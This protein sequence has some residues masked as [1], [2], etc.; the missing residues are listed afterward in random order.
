MSKKN[1][2]PAIPPDKRVVVIA[3]LHSGHLVGLTP[4]QYQHE[5]LDETETKHNKYIAVEKACWDYFETE[6]AKL[7]PVHIL[8]VNGDCTDGRGEKSGGVELLTTSRIKQAEMATKAILSCE[9]EY[10]VGTYG[11]DYHV[12]SDGEDI[13]DIVYKD[14][15]DSLGAAAVKWGAHEWF[16]VHGVTFDAKHHVSFSGVPHTQYTAV[17]RDALW[18]GV[19]S[20]RREA[21]AAQVI[22]RSHVHAFAYCG[23]KEYLAMTTPALQGMGS[24]YGARRC[25]RTVDFG[26]VHFDVSHTG[27]YTWQPHL[28]DL[29][30]QKPT[31]LH[32]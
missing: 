16:R 19:W 25:S 13:E 14:V 22:I 27:A 8:L 23:N 10:V 5:Y 11:T 15:A 32:F 1:G 7:K 29:P 24:R 17:A 20:L 31:V 18:S 12:A 4:R 21:P 28:A 30:E 2:K 3:D 9:P 26:F 6:I